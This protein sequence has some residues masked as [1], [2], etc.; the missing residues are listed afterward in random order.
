MAGA[1]KDMI[2][3]IVYDDIRCELIAEGASWSPDIADDMVAR[4]KDLWT[5]TMATI[6]E[7]GAY[8]LRYAQRVEEEEEEE[9]YEPED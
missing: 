8:E 7:S 2:V 4:I 1:S 3:R 5:A 6:V 9:E